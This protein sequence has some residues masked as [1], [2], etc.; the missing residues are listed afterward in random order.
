MQLSNESYSVRKC[1]KNNK[2]TPFA[3]FVLPNTT[4]ITDM[5]RKP[6]NRNN[7]QSM[8]AQLSYNNSPGA[9][10]A[11]VGIVVVVAVVC[12]AVAVGVGTVQAALRGPSCSVPPPR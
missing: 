4:F 11:A 9:A 10:A 2:N 12:V 6:S 8:V 3:I 7:S 5:P 1:K